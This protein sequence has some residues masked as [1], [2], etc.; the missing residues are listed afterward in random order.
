MLVDD[1]NVGFQGLHNHVVE[2]VNGTEV[3]N[4]H[5]L[6]ELVAQPGPDGFVSHTHTHTQTHTHT[7]T[8]TRMHACMYTWACSTYRSWWH[9]LGLMDS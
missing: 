1:I 2:K 4:L 8:H 9:S 3:L 7:H 6:Q 5:H